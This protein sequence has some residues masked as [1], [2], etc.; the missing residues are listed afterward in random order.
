M[1]TSENKPAASTEP[2]A[3][4][5]GMLHEADIGSGEK[6][7][8]EQDTQEMIEAIPPLPKDQAPSGGKQKQA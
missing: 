6:T 3:Q 7:P 1:S 2:G 4:A 8:G 5:P